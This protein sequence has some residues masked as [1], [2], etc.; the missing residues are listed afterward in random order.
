MLSPLSLKSHG[1]SHF[2]CSWVSKFKSY[3]PVNSTSTH[4]PPTLLENTIILMLSWG[5]A[6][7]GY[8]LTC[9][10]AVS[11]FFSEK[12]GKIRM[13]DTFTLRVIC[14]PLIKVSVN[15]CVIMSDLTR[16]SSSLQRRWELS[17]YILI[18]YFPGKRWMSS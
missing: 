7:A 6:F 1:G 11:F 13:P 2:C 12:R 16:N 14:R 5:R 8:Y 3:G 4:Q 18:I 10:Q 15:I 17:K 9:N